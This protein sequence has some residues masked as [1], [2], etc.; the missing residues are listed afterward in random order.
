MKKKTIVDSKLRKL[1][2]ERGYSADYVAMKLKIS[3]QL[4]W[5]MER[6]MKKIR[7][8]RLL[9]LADFFGVSLDYLYDREIKNP[10]FSVYEIDYI[11]KLRC[12][13]KEERKMIYK[14]I[15]TLYEAEENKKEE[16]SGEA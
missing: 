5:I 14:I 10:K 15:R 1:R 12:L 9:L 6:D 11:K 3:K 4:Y 2:T 16:K 7:A 8:D 13:T